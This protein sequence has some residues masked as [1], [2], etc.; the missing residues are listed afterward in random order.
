[1]RGSL[2]R[3]SISLLLLVCWNIVEYLPFVGLFIL[4]KYAKQKTKK[5]ND[6]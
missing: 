4:D 5:Q 2:E 6:Q 3:E 1:M